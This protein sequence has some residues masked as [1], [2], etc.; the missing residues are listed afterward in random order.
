[1]IRQPIGAKLHMRE[2]PGGSFVNTEVIEG[3]DGMPDLRLTTTPWSRRPVEV[4]IS[5]LEAIVRWATM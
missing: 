2:L 1:M 4:S 5:D 3:P